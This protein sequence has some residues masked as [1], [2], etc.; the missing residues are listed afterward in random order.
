[1]TLEIEQA[2]AAG[3]IEY[4]TKP[5]RLAGFHADLRRVLG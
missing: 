4:W 5:I 3:A 2:K 1:M